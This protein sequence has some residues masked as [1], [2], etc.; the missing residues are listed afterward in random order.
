MTSPRAR[1]LASTLIAGM[2]TIATPALAQTQAQTTTSTESTT[3]AGDQVG[4]TPAVPTP[5]ASP[6]GQGDIIV[7]GTL[8]RDPNLLSSAPVAAI[9]QGELQLRQ[10]NVAEEVLRT[11]PG[12][13]PSI[14]S[15][16]NNG[17]GGAAFVNLRGLGSNRNLVLLDGAR[18][19]PA[20]LGGQVDLNNIPLALLERLEVL[21]GGA[22]TTY[23]ADAVA[24]V[25]NFITKSDFSGMEANVSEQITQRGDGNHLRADLTLGANFD[26]GRGNA[27]LSLGYQESDPVYF[28]GP[29]RPGSNVTLESYDRFFVAG[30]GS[31]TTTPS[32]FDIGGGRK[33]QQVTPDGTNI[34]PFASS[35]NFN[36][37]NVFQVPFTR[38]NMYGA[39]HYD[40]ADHITVYARGLYSDNTVKTI[41][42]P[43]GVFGSS[44]TVPVSN[45]Y[46]STAQRTYLCANADTNT[47]IAGNQTL[48]TGECAAAAIAISPTDPNYRNFTFG[49]RRRTTE[50][51]PRVSDYHTQIFDFRAGVRGDITS[52][53]GFDISGSYGRSQN[54]QSIQNYVLLSR[55]R[56]ALLATNTTTCL[57]N[58]NG[59][60]PLN[61]FGANNSI[62]PAQTT[63][64]TN[65]S[66]S[67]IQTALGQARGVINGDLGFSSPFASQN[68]N[69]AAG[70]E[71][72]RYTAK[73]RSDVLA[74]TPGELGGAGGAQPDITGSFDVVEGFGELVVP[75]ITDR[76]FF[77]SLTAE[78]GVR[79]SHYKID[80]PG[81]P[82]FNTTTYKAGG[83]WEPINDI[84]LRGNYQRAV[85]APNIG[86]LFSP[87]STG[88][89][90]LGTDP[91]AGAAPRN[92][93][94]LRAVCIAQGAP[95]ATIGTIQNPTAGQANVTGGGNPF[96][97]PEVSNS[98]TFGAVVTPSFFRGFTATVD[99][100]H[101]KVNGAVSSP[102]PADLVAACFGANPTS[103]SA[104]A[105]TS[106]D[107]TVIRRN[108]ITGGLDGDPATTQ[109]L[110]GPSSNLGKIE[111][112]GIDLTAAYKMRL[113]SLFGEDAG[114]NLSFAGNWT[115]KSKFQA[116]PTSVNRDC[117]GFYSVNCGS[118]Q[119]KFSF[120]QRTTLTMGK[121][122][123]SLLWRYI[124]PVDFEPLQY[125]SDVAAAQA[126]PANCPNYQTDSGDQIS[127]GG[128]ACIVD[129]PFRHIGAKHY[130]DLSTRFAATENFEM[131]ITVQNLFDLQPPTVGGTVG[132]TTYNGG[133]TYPSTYDALGRRFAV[134]ARLK[135]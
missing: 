128:G 115:E 47:A 64:I 72:R 46:L 62:T 21:T 96:L 61:I 112:A 130:F 84:K 114:L 113:G 116:T 27:V 91:C 89:T 76:P 3:A 43:S 106:A 56:Q 65:D 55:V 99:Y 57:T 82:K 49:L 120:N 44:V 70:V 54:T 129:S 12:I 122:D 123:V 10:T 29:D 80:A 75:L 11:I 97:K 119:P 34:A 31:S 13:V 104:S 108:P 42:A 33:R 77:Q 100:Y 107:C 39:A 6:T 38:Y 92:N 127:N 22:S 69:F 5:A 110:F 121:V 28:G 7:T 26:D 86:E 58:T 2:A 19:A 79:Q 8:I 18:I 81:T 71:Y 98:Y 74:K 125:A 24:G 35:F 9:G 131:T 45:P 73:Q 60:V 135:F 40:V 78:A 30:Q 14:G 93:P 95:V 48:T 109:G 4:V 134:G 105:A 1:L 63:F 102:T 59:C 16:V 126:S 83:T 101:I 52:N 88:L 50:V 25:V 41:I 37:Y 133:N 103:P 111:T 20:G 23:G 94:N 90:N 68:V 17:N 67:V 51:G 53:I 36:P 132:S 118:I 117:V 15:N 124:H 32:A 66:T 87:V 85:R